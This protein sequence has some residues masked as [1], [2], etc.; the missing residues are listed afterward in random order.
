[1][2]CDLKML[3]AKHDFWSLCDYASLK[4]V[5]IANSMMCIQNMT[6]W[7]VNSGY[8]GLTHNHLQ[9]PHLCYWILKNILEIKVSTQFS[10]GLTEL[11][12]NKGELTGMVN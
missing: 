1:M 4:F 8:V 2:P 9:N 5:K 6:S 10:C 11:T 3:Q 7:K 12:D